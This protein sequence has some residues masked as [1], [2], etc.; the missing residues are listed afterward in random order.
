MCC[1]KELGKFPGAKQRAERKKGSRPVNPGLD[2]VIPITEN[3]LQACCNILLLL[4]VF[5]S[6]RIINIDMSKREIMSRLRLEALIYYLD[7]SEH[8]DI[9]VS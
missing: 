7:R 8:D 2:T 3:T 9:I 6:P 1:D 4:V 5:V